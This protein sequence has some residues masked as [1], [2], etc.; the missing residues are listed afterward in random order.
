MTKIIEARGLRLEVDHEVYTPREDSFMVIDILHEREFAEEYFCEIGSGSG[1]ISLSL[2]AR[3]DTVL[4]SEINP[5]AARQ[6]HTNALHN[7][8][9]NVLTVCSDRNAP[10]RPGALPETIIFN[11]PYLPEDPDIDPYSPKHEK[12][13][14]VGGKEGDEVI[15]ELLTD[16]PPSQHT[17]YTIISSLATNPVAFSKKHPQWSTRVLK[18]ENMGFETVWLLKLEA[19]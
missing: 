4:V 5:I 3:S 10:F 6:T 13:Q 8:F 19:N 12:Q 11:P 16:L 1:I 9:D 7:R 14:L 2:A 17:V 18:A 15:S